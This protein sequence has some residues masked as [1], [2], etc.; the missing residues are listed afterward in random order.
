MRT[1]VPVLVHR[2]TTFAGSLSVSGAARIEGHV[3]GEVC[4]RGSLIVGTHARIDGGVTV[5]YL[6]VHG[7]V[8]GPVVAE[9]VF[10]G[11]EGRIEGPVEA[12][13]VQWLP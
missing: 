12:Q 11:P 10:V 1:P 4:G 13:L 3:G 7:E 5:P 9:Q 8:L 6:E 2:G